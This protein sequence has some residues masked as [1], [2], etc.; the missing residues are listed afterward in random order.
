MKKE[1][2]DNSVPIISK[3]L[4]DDVQKY[5][6][7]VMKDMIENDKRYTREE[8]CKMLENSYGNIEKTSR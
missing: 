1:L 7:D 2:E 6:P 3:K 4:W 5:L 8:L